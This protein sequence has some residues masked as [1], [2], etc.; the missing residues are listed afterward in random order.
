MS[1]FVP[2]GIAYAKAGD[3]PA[4]QGDLHVFDIATGAEVRDVSE[5]NVREGWLVRAKRN[6]AGELFLNGDEIAQ[7]CVEGQFEILRRA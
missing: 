7:E 3:P 6:E 4:D 5:V 2:T 1:D